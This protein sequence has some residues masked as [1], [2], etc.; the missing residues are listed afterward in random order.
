M[1]ALSKL[2]KMVH[3]ILVTVVYQLKRTIKTTFIS[4]II[5]VYVQSTM[6]CRFSTRSSN[7]R[8]LRFKVSGTPGT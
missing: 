2:P 6:P 4:Y 7:F 3:G 5:D 8:V 1:L